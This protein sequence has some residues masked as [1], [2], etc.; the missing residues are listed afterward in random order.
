LTTSPR[1]PPEE[2]DELEPVAPVGVVVAPPAVGVAVAAG[3]VAAAAAPLHPHPHP[4]PHPG[5][6]AAMGG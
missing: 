5:L 6:A 4:H 3:W 2:L 1:P